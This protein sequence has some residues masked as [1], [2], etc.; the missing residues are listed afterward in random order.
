MLV[1]RRIG[2]LGGADGRRHDFSADEEADAG[3]KSAAG[4]PLSGAKAFAD[5]STDA[6]PVCNTWSAERSTCSGSDG[7]ALV[8]PRKPLR[9]SAAPADARAHAGADASS[10]AA[11]WK[12]KRCV[13]DRLV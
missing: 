9:G 13:R 10:T 6:I 4:E 8:E 7:L 1:L 5:A 2:E 12:S 3:S 11:A